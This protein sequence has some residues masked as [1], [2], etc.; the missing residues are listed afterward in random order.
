[1]VQSKDL[2]SNAFHNH[3]GHGRNGAPFWV[4]EGTLGVV[5]TGQGTDL[6]L[7]DAGPVWSLQRNK[8]EKEKINGCLFVPHTE[9]CDTV[10]GVFLLVFL[11]LSGAFKA[12][13]LHTTHRKVWV[14]VMF[15]NT[16]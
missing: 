6:L 16:V 14:R 4:I 7:W 10:L 3:P 1:M 13:C 15:R 12:A 8:E 11:Y 2:A 9:V 5:Q